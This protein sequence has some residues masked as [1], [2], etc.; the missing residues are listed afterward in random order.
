LGSILSEIRDELLYLNSISKYEIIYVD[1]NSRDDSLGELHRFIRKL[2]RNAC[3]K[4]RAIHMI[5]NVGQ[6]NAI[7]AGLE[8][9]H[10]EYF[11]TLDSDVQDPASVISLL[12]KQLQVTRRSLI[13][14]SRLPST[15]DEVLPVFRREFIK[16]Q[17]YSCQNTQI[18]RAA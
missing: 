13:V 6:G 4:V 8:I 10:G 2:K 14:A 5:R 15:A 12:V 18:R 17:G 1:D 11:I 3:V 16:A 7:L 9:S